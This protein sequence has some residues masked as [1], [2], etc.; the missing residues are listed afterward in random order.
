MITGREEGGEE[1]GVITEEGSGL[2]GM[3]YGG[4]ANMERGRIEGSD[5][6]A[7]Y[8]GGHEKGTLLW[9]ISRPAHVD[10]QNRQELPQRKEEKLPPSA[11]KFT[12]NSP[13]PLSPTDWLPHK[14]KYA[15]THTLRLVMISGDLPSETFRAS[16]WPDSR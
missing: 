7:R 9:A 13:F 4:G 2:Q 12:P 1:G 15:P 10:S 3:I 11:Q 8:E 5:I 16:L 6:K 14:K